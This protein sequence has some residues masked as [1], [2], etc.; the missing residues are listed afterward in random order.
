MSPSGVRILA[1]AKVNLH[2]AVG[3]LR[4]DGYHDVVTILQ[5]IGLHDTVTLRPAPTFSFA[6]TPGI[7]I[8]VEQNL[9]YRA[10]RLC[11]ERY[12]RDLDVSISVEKRIPAGAG[13]GGASA[14]A[15]AV[16]SGLARMWSRTIA[17]PVALEVAR[18]LGADVPFF[19]EGGAALFVGRGDVLERRLTALDASIVLVKPAGPVPTV[20]AYRA[21]DLIFPAPPSPPAADDLAAALDSG[22]TA[23]VA[24]R[25]FN[26]MTEAAIAVLPD[27]GRALDLVRSADGVL[28]ATVAGSGSSVFGICDSRAAAEAVADL[29]RDAGLWAEAT[30]T[31][32][33]GCVIETL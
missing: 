23:A 13:L 27:V 1:P 12:G 26:N 20:A 25:I 22:D 7:G 6:C 28:G 17:D 16:I 15:A 29:A 3:A 11:S 10:A 14:D 33:D 8:P 18:S 21:F 32:R 31:L 4:S 9:A 5:S 24:T 19:L 30:S 2:L